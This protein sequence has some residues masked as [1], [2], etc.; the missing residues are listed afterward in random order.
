MHR[1]CISIAAGK[2]GTVIQAGD[3]PGGPG[4][5][6]GEAVIRARPGSHGRQPAQDGSEPR[7]AAGRREEPGE[8]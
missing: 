1:T 5:T 7:P 4:L 2:T 8:A 3:I 6:G